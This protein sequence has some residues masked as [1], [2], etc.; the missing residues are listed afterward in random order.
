VSTK[1][2]PLAQSGSCDE[3]LSWAG[4]GYIFLGGEISPAAP[5]GKLEI[6]LEVPLGA[7]GTFFGSRIDKCALAVTMNA[8]EAVAG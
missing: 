6:T 5:F 4:V 7:L 8:F 2:S 1:Q 3:V